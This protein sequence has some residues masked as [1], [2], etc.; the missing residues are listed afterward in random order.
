MFRQNSYWSCL[1]DLL[2]NILRAKNQECSKLTSTLRLSAESIA[3][4]S[5]WFLISQHIWYSVTAQNEI[6]AFVQSLLHVVHG[7]HGCTLRL[8]D[9]YSWQLV[10]AIFYEGL[11]DTLWATLR[12]LWLQHC[13]LCDFQSLEISVQSHRYLREVTVVLEQWALYSFNIGPSLCPSNL[14]THLGRSH[15][16]WSLLWMGSIHTFF[17]RCVGIVSRF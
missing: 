11:S 7:K 17:L 9:G 8:Y 13:L 6:L 1:D 14:C 10:T 15:L 2:G 12:R 3:L 5:I 16:F 4:S